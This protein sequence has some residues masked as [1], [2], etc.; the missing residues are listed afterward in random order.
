MSNQ[1]VD[2]RIVEM[3]FDNADFESKVARTLESL[4][5]LRENTKMED[6]GKGMENLAKGVKNVDV[7][8][9]A[10]SVEQLNQRFSALGIVGQEVMRN[11]T[12][13]AMRMGA[14][15]VDAITMAPKDGWKEFELNTDSIKT[16]LNSAKDANGLPVTLEAVNKSLAELNR[17]SDQTIYSF[18]DMTSNIGKFT[19]AGVDLDSAVTAIQGVANVAA[20]A[21]ANANDA[22]RAMYNFGQALGSGSVKLI[23]WKSIENAN[24]ATIDFKEQLIQTAEELGTVRKEGDKYVSTTTSLQGKVSDAFTAS[25]GFNDSLSAQWMTADVL[26][27]TLAKYTD[28]QSELGQKAIEAAT[29][30]N[31]LTKLVDTLKESMGSGWMQTWQLIVGDYEESTQLWTSI[32]KELDGIIQKTSE[33]RNNLLQTWKD[34][35]GRND[36][37]EGFANLWAAAKEFVVPIR[38]LFINLLPPISGEGLAKLT[39]GFKEFTARL[40]PVKETAD[41]VVEKVQEGSKAVEEVTDRAEKFNQV[42]QE[43]IDG[44]WGNGQERID[45]LH[46]AGYAFENLQNVVNKTLGSTK[47]YETTMSDNEAVNEKVAK[48]TKDLAEKQVDYKEAVEK[49][50][51][52]VWEH[53]SIID[54]MA[55]VVLGVSSSVKLMVGVV[56]EG[57]KAF[58]ELSGGVHPVM[59]A[60]NLIMDVLG[61]IGRHMYT[62][63][64][65]L[66]QFKSLGEVFTAVREKILGFTKSFKDVGGNTSQLAAVYELVVKLQSAF[67]TLKNNVQGV[68]NKFT[69]LTNKDG[70]AAAKTALDTLGKYVSGTLLIAVNTLARAFNTAM[71]YASKLKNVL[72]NSIVVTKLTDA[73]HDAKDAVMGFWNNLNLSTDGLKQYNDVLSDISKG[74]NIVSQVV[75][76]VFRE[77]FNAVLF[78]LQKFEAGAA[79]AFDIFEKNGTV[80]KANTILTHLKETFKELPTIVERFFTSLKSGKVPS[81][82]ELSH[83]L[84]NF[85]QSIREFGSG[86]RG[87]FQTMWADLVTNLTNG[88]MSLSNLQLPEGLKQVVDKIKAVFTSFAGLTGDASST[89]QSFITNVVDKVKSLDLRGGFITALIGAVALFVARWSKVGK[90]ASKLLKALTT[91]IKNGGK[92]ATDTADK[93]SGFLKIAA[94]IAIIAA[95]IWLLAKVPAD[96]FLACAV[97]VGIAFAALFGAIVA[98]GKMNIDSDKLKSIGIAFAGIGVAVALV[99]ASVKAFA[100]MKPEEIVKG[101]VLVGATVAGMVAAIKFTGEVS[102]GA[103]AA[104][105]GLAAGVLILSI[106]VRSFAAIKFE[107]L[108]KGGAAV[109]YFIVAMTAAMKIADGA[110]GDGFIGLAASIVILTFAVKAIAKMK[111]GDLLKGGVGVIALIAAMAIASRQAKDVDG[112]SFKSMSSAIKMLTVAMLILS[113]IPTVQL[114]VISASLVLIFKSLTDAMKELKQMDPKESLYVAIALVALLAP[115]GLVLGLLAA[116]TNPDSVL[117]IA[118]GIAAILW[119]FGTASPAIQ[120][121][122]LVPWQ[123]GINAAINMEIFIGAVALALAALGALDKYTGA[124]DMMVQGAELLGRC[125]HAFLEALIF[126]E[127]DPSETIEKIGNSISSFAEKVTGFIDTVKDLDPNVG[128]NA[129]NLAAAILTLC[130]AEVLDAVAGWI[131]GK[132]DVGNFGAAISSITTAIMDINNSVSGGQYDAK[133]VNQ[134]IKAVKGLVEIA[135]ALPKQGGLLQGLAGAQ[136]LGRFGT[137][138]ATFIKGGFTEFV[139]QINTIGYSL[140]AGFIVRVE[141]VKRATKALCNLANDIPETKSNFM[142]FFTGKQ[143]L[144]EFAKQMAAFMTGGFIDFVD[145]VNQMPKVSVVGIYTQIV[146][147]TDAMISLAKKLKD[148]TSIMS[149]FT[150]ENDL[151][152]FGKALAGFGEGLKAFSTSVVDVDLGKTEAIKTVIEQYGTL[153]ANENLVASGLYSFSVTLGTLGA[154]LST[155]FTNTSEITPEYMTVLIEKLSSLHNVL[156]IIAGSNYDGVSNFVTA[157]QEMA[158]AGISGFIE[159]F[160]SESDNAETAAVFLVDVIVKTINGKLPDFTTAGGKCTLVFA[161]GVSSRYRGVVTAAGKTVANRAISAIQSKASEFARKGG[162]CALQFCVGLSE[163]YKGMLTGAGKSVANSALDGVKGHYN[164][165]FEEGQH[166]AE[167]YAEGIRDKAGEVADEARQMVRDGINA[168]KDEQASASPSKVFRGLGNDGGEGYGLGFRD[169]AGFVKKSVIH[170]ADEGIYAMKKSVEKMRGLVD[171]DFDYAPTIT[172][173]VDMSQLASGVRSSNALLN[174]LNTPISGLTAQ[175][176]FQQSNMS[177]AIPTTDTVNYSDD[178][179]KLVENTTLLIKA[180]RENRIAVIDGDRVFNYVNRRFGQA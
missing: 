173:V 112:D 15:V 87:N 9:L 36:L 136:D 66:I 135:N 65:W 29:K 23:D 76:T 58:K 45:R 19:N 152:L 153:N 2:Q 59:A 146:P 109:T 54:N 21:G 48:S 84:S 31:T 118:I 154:A 163:R 96:R 176:A 133:A 94:G 55:Y 91:F 120:K 104:F 148:N 166:A 52:V 98:L 79:H 150:K 103:G 137:Q 116:F 42:V 90:N 151:S 126:G 74:I 115:I 143:D 140:N 17:Y 24:M 147:A 139:H 33:F 12:D 169:M 110:S 158:T 149:W 68:V 105:A 111:T 4:T 156:L 56:N 47:T 78:V 8:A 179:S 95:S 129:K 86:L 51:D 22:S 35:G 124:G 77:A 3:R 101:L 131:T 73:Y 171:E 174:S 172:P 108:I 20:L 32:Y 99:A 125:V 132:S 164:E 10:A 70:I 81:L 62:V 63:S 38:D 26:T 25:Q 83:N 168:A 114:I 41:K 107:D 134:V 138:M 80:E 71:G 1:T 57:V 157:L 72:A 167:G 30:V 155:F 177:N 13:A 165:F 175:L 117:K 7:N 89:V 100:Q 18:S 61:N 11:L 123:A 121:L 39:N 67:N 122:A 60:L 162:E 142:A 159:Q 93:F 37:I 6:A 88:I 82:D 144:G 44:K 161:N 53:S 5:K 43:I 16:I 49:S 14:Q 46:E 92:A 127:G 145:A 113:K 75:G 69:E 106:A 97:T 178:I 85:I 128:T 27:K 28:G 50:N 64:T 130:G 40:A 119:A 160:R 34:L 141:I 102:D 180:A 170:T